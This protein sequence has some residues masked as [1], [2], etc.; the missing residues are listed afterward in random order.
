MASER[1]QPAGQV[2]CAHS[3]GAE[4]ALRRGCHVEPPGLCDCPHH[5]G[6][7]NSPE[8][9]AMSLR[10]NVVNGLRSLFRKR[11][12]ESELDEELSFFVEAS[13]SDKLRRGMAPE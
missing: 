7:R 5:G 13:T 4:G 6:L 8:G 2:L 1:E 12:I 11:A 9:F 10:S 3:A